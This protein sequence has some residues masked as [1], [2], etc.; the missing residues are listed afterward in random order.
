MDDI[1]Y[2]VVFFSLMGIMIIVT[3]V[4]LI[5]R[6]ERFNKWFDSKFRCPHDYTHRKNYLE[7][8]TTISTCSKCGRQ[9][10]NNDGEQNEEIRKY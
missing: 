10:I 6:E 1:F 5:I 3:V 7:S 8:E 4:M 2:E 9:V